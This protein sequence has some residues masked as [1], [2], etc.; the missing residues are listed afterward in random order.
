MKANIYI[1]KGTSKSML[2]R[3]GAMPILAILFIVLAI[4]GLAY[5]ATNNG[6]SIFGYNNVYK[7]NW[8]SIECVQN[9]DY[10]LKYSAYIDA[11]P[12][13]KC[14]DYT[15]ECL[16][17]IA[18]DRSGG[19]VGTLYNYQVCNLDGTNCAGLVT[20]NTNSQDDINSFTI[21][22]GKEVMFSKPFAVFNNY[23]QIKATKK[24]KSFYIKGVENGK[25]FTQESCVLSS[26]LRNKVPSNG[27]NELTFSGANQYQNYMIDWVLTATQTYSYN[28]KEVV[29]QARGLYDIINQNMLDG[30]AIKLQGNKIADVECCPAE[31]NCDAN[32]FKFKQNTI[33][34]CT[35][36]SECANGGNP[37][38]Q[39]ATS[40]Y[41]YSCQANTCVKGETKNV[42][43][44]NTAQCTLVHGVKSVCDLSIANFG[45]CITS[46]TPNVCGDGVCNSNDGENFQT[47][48]SDC[49]VACPVGTKLVTT[50]TGNT[51]LTWVGIEQPTKVQSCESSNWWNDYGIWVIVV[52]ALALMFYF[53]QYLHNIKL[54]YATAGLAGLY[55]LYANGL[56]GVVGITTLIVL[57][58]LAV[59]FWLFRVQILM[60][61][62]RFGI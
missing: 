6:L 27:L 42:E 20:K 59:L 21:D 38:A 15:N 54:V 35:Y 47:C 17:S 34:Q 46:T 19:I 45:K 31:A 36:S 41:K 50:Y 37:I 52:I 9:F 33:K 28:N 11:V 61:L 49:A 14:D 22:K 62:R 58:I 18:R 30:S 10:D 40:Y 24:A 12:T 43:C 4:A 51:F 23:N 55:L 26:E 3:K 1:T 8:G 57:G 25:I 13:L 39:T 48:P 16:I 7:Q 2:G 53:Y 29:C 60:V 56:F 32:T 5:V 44:T